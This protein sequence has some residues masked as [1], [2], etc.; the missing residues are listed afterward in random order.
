MNIF[1]IVGLLLGFGGVVY[2]YLGDEGVLSALVRPTAASIV[3]GGTFG[4][5][6]LSFPLSYIKQVPKALKMIFFRKKKNYAEVIELLYNLANVARRDGILAMEA[7]AEKI[8][9]PFIKKGLLYVADGVE[10]EF[11]KEVL[12]NEIEAK[13][14]EYERGAKVM[15][16]AGGVSPAMGVLGTVMGMVSILR[17]MGGDTAALGAKISTA[18]IATMYGVGSANLLWL[19]LAGHI[20]NCAAEDEEYMGLIVTGLLSILEGEYPARMKDNLMAVIGGLQD[21]KDKG[22]KGKPAGEEEKSA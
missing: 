11:L 18:F 19:P 22:K 4:F 17:D 10:P 15:E 12:E 5:I 9:D 6:F 7:E 1:L 20:K 8:K 3:F 21:G 14:G 2:G 16:G 13:T